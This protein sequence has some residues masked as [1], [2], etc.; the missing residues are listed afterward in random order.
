MNPVYAVFLKNALCD[1]CSGLKLEVQVQLKSTVSSRALE[2]MHLLW[3]Q[4]WPKALT[5]LFP[6]FS[7]YNLTDTSL[8]SPLYD[9]HLAAEFKDLMDIFGVY[10]HNFKIV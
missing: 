7:D 2:E 5:Y 10:L 8:F 3:V 4:P 1:G 9:F 6:V